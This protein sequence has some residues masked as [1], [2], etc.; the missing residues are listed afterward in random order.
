VRAS[1]YND[2][3]FQSPQGQETQRWSAYAKQYG[4]LTRTPTDFAKLSE[5]LAKAIQEVLLKNADPKQ[6]L[7]AAAKEYNA[8]HKE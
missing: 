4:R 5:G 2:A 1:V 6:A 8:Q 7:D 3:F